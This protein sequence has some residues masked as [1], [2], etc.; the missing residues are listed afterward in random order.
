MFCIKC[1]ARNP[2]GSKFCSTCGAAMVDTE[3]LNGSAANQQPIHPQNTG[4]HAVAPTPQSSATPTPSQPTAPTNHSPIAPM[5]QMPI[6]TTPQPPAAPNSTNPNNSSYSSYG[7]PMKVHCPK[8]GSDRLLSGTDVTTT[9]KS[10][11][12]K[13]GLGCL[14]FL[15]WGPLGLL[16][17]LCGMGSKTTTKVK[18]KFVCQD[19]GNEFPT[20]EEKKRELAVGAAQGIIIGIIAV[21]V[22]FGFFGDGSI[23]MGLF[24][25][26]VGVLMV[27]GGFVCI[28]ERSDI[29]IEGYD[30][31]CFKEKDKS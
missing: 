12:Y 17:G 29:D 31:S 4:S 20:I 27:I 11:G 9:T 13:S 28:K 15:M 30:A 23:F 7:N 8:C 10:S 16:C 3:K 24:C 19:C 26:V 5:P 6:I 25:L 22:S 21:F 14:G 1:G 18:D 2:D